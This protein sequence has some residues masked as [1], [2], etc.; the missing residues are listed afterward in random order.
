MKTM[1]AKNMQARVQLVGLL[2]KLNDMREDIDALIGFVQNNE[3][4]RPAYALSR[5]LNVLVTEAKKA[6]GLGDRAIY[7]VLEDTRLAD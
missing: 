7:D 2:G 3:G 6:L 5:D 1:T 4:L